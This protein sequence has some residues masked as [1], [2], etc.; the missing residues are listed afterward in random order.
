MKRLIRL[1][2]DF[3][4]NYNLDNCLTAHYIA[5]RAGL[6]DIYH[7]IHDFIMENFFDISNTEEF[8]H[9]PADRLSTLLSDDDV[10]VEHELQLFQ[11]VLRWTENQHG[12]ITRD[13]PLILKHIRFGLMSPEEI[14][15]NVE[16]AKHLMNIPE[17]YILVLEAFRY[18]SLRASKGGT[19][20]TPVK[21]RKG[22]NKVQNARRASIAIGA[23]TPSPAVIASHLARLEEKMLEEQNTNSEHAIPSSHTE[24]LDDKHLLLSVGGVYKDGDLDDPGRTV[25]V[26]DPVRCEWTLMTTMKHPRNHHVVQVVGRFLYVIGGSNPYADGGEFMSPVNTACKYDMG[27]NEWSSMAPMLTARVFFQAAVLDGDIYVVGGQGSKGSVLSSVEKYNPATDKWS[28]VCSL[29]SPR[30]AIALA[31]HHGLLYAVGGYCEDVKSPVLANV[32][33]YHP[34]NDRWMQKNPMR[35]ARCHASL[36]DV[37][38]K[39]YLFGGMV[40]T[41]YFADD[42]RSLPSVDIYR[43]T[44]DIWEYVTDL[45][46]ARHEAGICVVGPKVYIIGGISATE[47]LILSSVECY[48][49]L[50]GIWLHPGPTELPKPALGHSCCTM[51]REL[52]N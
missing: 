10:N 22:M 25:N 11:A 45:T 23:K 43:D 4:R 6:N 46:D 24:K 52:L 49:T 39:L 16:S 21:P 7:E 27:K 14:V 44:E 29:S 26:Y 20:P 40:K 1:C 5:D 2:T 31:V 3:L 8:L 51:P 36:A 37:Q 42:C 12:D 28:H 48:D 41:S 19:R 13:A 38:G 34:Q 47:K 17:C 50:E 18:F 30:Y 33:C 15:Q 9:Y 35:Y 32:E